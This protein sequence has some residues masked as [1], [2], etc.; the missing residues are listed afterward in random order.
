M[1]RDGALKYLF[2]EEKVELLGSIYTHYSGSLCSTTIHPI[3]V[4]WAECQKLETTSMY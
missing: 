4:E 1:Y 2:Y 3:I